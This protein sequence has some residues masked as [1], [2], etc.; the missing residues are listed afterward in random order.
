[1]GV[2][3]SKQK[4]P[5]AVRKNDIA[6][7]GMASRFPGA[8]DYQELWKILEAGKSAIQEVPGS[9]WDWQAFWGNPKTEINKSNSKWGGFLENVESFDADF[10]G[11]AAKEVERMDPQQRMML[12]LTWSCFEDAALPPS[13]LSGK[14]VGVFLGV[15]N[16]DYKELQEKSNDLSIDAH[17]ST[18]TASAI[19]PNRVSYYFN[20]KGP[21]IPID[22]ACSSSLN[23]IH[24]AIQ[25]LNSGE[26]TLAVAGGINLLLTPTRHISFSKT[27]MLSPTGSCKT[28]DDGA[29]GYVRGEGAGL[30]LLK[31][32]DQALRDKNNI[33]GIIKGSA[34]NHGG[35]TYSL[36]YPNSD[37]QSEVIVDAQK[38]A[39][40]TSD[41]ISYMEAHGTGTPKGD[42][43][44]FKGLVD[45][46][47]AN[48]AN[49]R[50]SKNY[51]GLGS[52]KTNLGHLE[53]AAGVAGVIK[54]LL[55]MR[56][57]QLPRL[58]NF[59][60]LN[61]RIEVTDTPFYLVTELKE[62][63]PL[64]DK[65]GKLLPRRA[66]VS[67]F[68]FGGT[69]AHV[70]IQEA[71]ESAVIA[72]VDKK[73]T[74]YYLIC[75]SAKTSEALVRKQRDLATWLTNSK[76]PVHIADV[77]KTL[78]AGRE[79]F[80]ERMAIVAESTGDLAVK[81]A[82]L[83]EHGHA[84]GCIGGT[85]PN[86]KIESIHQLFVET[87]KNV[88][89]A[90]DAKKRIGD[91][92]YFEKLIVLAELYSSGYELDWQK[93]WFGVYGKTVSMPVYPFDK[94]NHWIAQG[95]S[96]VSSLPVK[97]D[98]R[99][100]PLLGRNTSDFRR[101][102]FSTS[103][104]GNEFF[105]RD[106]IIKGKKI[107]PA[108]AYLEMAR[109]AMSESV[110]S[111]V[112]GTLCLRNIVWAEPVVVDDGTTVN[113][114][115]YP[116]GEN[117][118][119]FEIFGEDHLNRSAI[120][121]QGS[122]Q[123]EVAAEYG[124][125]PLSDLEKSCNEDLLEKKTC[126]LFFEGIGFNYG[127]AH[128]ALQTV[129][130]GRN[131]LLAKLKLDELPGSADENYWLHPSMADAALQA[132]LLLNEFSAGEQ[133]KGQSYLPF[134]LDL[135]SIAR[136]C[137]SEMWA[138]VT[139]NDLP[140]KKQGSIRRMDIDLCDKD[141]R[142]CVRM[143]GFSFK[144]IT[145]EKFEE[146]GNDVLLMTQ[147]WLERA[148]MPAISVTPYADHLVMACGFENISELH[149]KRELPGVRLIILQSSE[150][151]FGQQYQNHVAN[152]F[153]EIQSLLK[154]KTNGKILV[155]ILFKTEV[156]VNLLSGLSALL[157]TAS[158]E[159]PNIVGQV[160]EVSSSDN[161]I[162]IIKES[163]ATAP[164]HRIRY[165]NGRRFVLGWKDL[166]NANEKNVP[167][168][169]GGVY[170]ITGGAGGLGLIF[171]KEI[172]GKTKDVSLVLAGR[173]TMNKVIQERV[174]ALQ[175]LGA[176]VTYRQ[177]DV[178]DRPA[179]TE[180]IE[181]IRKDFN[182]LNGIIHSAGIVKDNFMIRKSEDELTS[183]LSPKVLGVTYL[184]EAT[185]DVPLDFFILFSS[186]VGSLGNTG[187][188][189]YAAA[190]GYLDDYARYRNRL[191]AA[192][193]RKGHAI[194]INWPL[195]RE[196]GMRL[197]KEMEKV[198]LERMKMN[199]LDTVSGV[200]ALYR[201]FASGESQVMI[202]SGDL[203]KLRD[204]FLDQRTP[205]VETVLPVFDGV[206]NTEV[207]DVKIPE[208]PISEELAI[209][210][211]KELLS[212][213]IKRPV[214][215]IDADAA[216]DQYGIDSIMVVQM[217]DRMESVF[218]TLPKTLFF[219]FQT[220][221]ELAAYFKENHSQKLRI[222][223][224]SEKAP[225]PIKAGGPRHYPLRELS[226][227]HNPVPVVN[228]THSRFA[229]GNHPGKQ[230]VV[231]NGSVSSPLDVA[232]IGVAGRYPQ[233]DNLQQF[234]YNLKN[235]K[236]CITEIPKD[237]WDYQLYFDADKEKEGKSYSK[238]GGFVNDVDKFDPLFF[239]ITP[240]EAER[241]DPQE[242]LF[243]QC[244]YETIE[245][246]GYT[247]QS[248]SGTSRFGLGN[249]VGVYVG[250]MYEEYQLLGA[251]ETLLGRPVALW[252]L[253][254]SIANRVSYFCDF[255]GPSMAI[256]TMCSS[257]ITAIH[258]AC[259][260]IA[261]GKCELAIAGGVNVSVHP[262]K[263][264][265][266]SQGRFASS[267]GRCESFGKGGDGY[268]PGE[269]VG[270]VLLKPLEKAITDGDHIYG[271]IKSTA[272]NHGG[273]TN[274]Y[275]VPNPKAQAS[276]ISDALAEGG[277]DARAISYLE[278]H[279]TGTSLGDPI[280][281]L[282]LSKSFQE[283]T[284]E[285]QFC[286]IGSAKSNIGHCESA[287]GIAGVTK[288]LLQLKHKQIVPS[289]H[290]EVL[291]ENINFE[292]SPFVVQK[293]LT[294]WKRPLIESN[295][296]RKEYPRCAGISSFGAGGANAHMVIEEYVP[297]NESYRETPA[298]SQ[299]GSDPVVI[300]LSGKDDDRLKEQARQLLSIT[301]PD[302]AGN[303]T[304]SDSHLAD[305]AYTLQIGRE[306]MESRLAVIVTSV[307]EL[308]SKLGDY[309]S[310]RPSAGLFYGHTNAIRPKQ[311]SLEEIDIVQQWIDKNNRGSILEQWVTGLKV[312]WFEINKTTKHRRRI[313]LPTYPFRKDRYWV[314]EAG[315]GTGLLPQ[316]L[317]RSIIH[318][319]V[320]KNISDF[321][322]QR[323]SVML[324]GNE[325]FLKDHVVKG[326]KVLPAAA[327][328]EM[329][330]ESV[331]QFVKSLKYEV[332]DIQL[333][334]V[335][336]L[337][338]CVVDQDGINLTVELSPDEDGIIRVEVRNASIDDLTERS[339]YSHGNA[340]LGSANSLVDL[341]ETGIFTL[342]SQCNS[343]SLTKETI[344]A[345]FR[346]I[347][348][349]YGPTH[350]CL[351]EVHVGLNKI[352]AAISLPEDS[353]EHSDYV[354]YP[355]L[356][357]S[358]LQATLLW[359]W[360]DMDVSMKMFL[361]TSI[362]R[363][364]I[365]RP[366]P[367]TA[368]VVIGDRTDVFASAD[369][370]KGSHRHRILDLDIY[371]TNGEHCLGL[372]GITLTAANSNPAALH[373]KSAKTFLLFPEWKR[374]SINKDGNPK[375]FDRALLIVCGFKRAGSEVL[376]QLPGMEVSFLDINGTMDFVAGSSEIF[377][378]VQSLL[379]ERR[380]GDTFVQIL[381]EDTEEGRMYASV[382]AMLKTA[383]K[384][385]PKFIGQVICVPAE[386]TGELKDIVE[387]NMLSP[388]DKDVRYIKNDR[389]VLG[390][391]EIEGGLKEV[392]DLPWKDEAVYLI[393][394]GGGGLG[395]IMADEIIR[396]TKGV[397][398]VLTGRSAPNRTTLDKIDSWQKS[399]SRIMYKQA[400]VTDQSS[401]EALVASIRNECGSLN[402][403]IHSAGIIRDNFFIN[404]T[405][406]EWTEV[407]APKVNGI[408]YLDQLTKND[409]LDFF[410]FFSSV[411]GALGNVGQADYATANAFMDNYA[412]GRNLLVSAGLRKGH[413]LSVNWPLWKEGGMHVHE[414]AENSLFESMGIRPLPTRSAFEGLYNAMRTGYAQ[415]MI[416]EGDAKRIH[417]KILRREIAFEKSAEVRA[418]LTVPRDNV[419]EMAISYFKKFLSSE[420]KLP[421][422]KIN[423]EVSMEEYGID[424]VMVMKMTS[425][426]EKLFGPLS[427]TL[428]FEY[429]NIKELS[430][431]FVDEHYVKVTSILGVGGEAAYP[432]AGPLTNSGSN[433]VQLNRSN[434][435]ERIKPTGIRRRWLD[436][437]NMLDRPTTRGTNQPVQLDI[438]II[439][440]SG[441]YPQAENLEKFWENL[442]EG[443]DSVTEIPKVRW[444]HSLYFDGDK[445]KAGK[446][447]S[448]WGGFLSGVDEFDPLFF[449]ISPREAE[450]M[451]P[452]ERLFLQCAY[453]TVEDAGY[454]RETI[455]SDVN[456]LSGN[457]GVFA[458]VMYEEYQLFGVAESMKGRNTAL[459][460]NPA[461]IA[462]RVSYF[463][464]F[465]G[466]SMSVDTM[467]SSSLTAIYLACQSIQNGDCKAAI[468]GGVNVSIHPNKYLLLA[469]G[470]FISSKGRCESF[471]VGG[472]GY[473]P[474]E[475][476][477]SVFLKPLSQA[478]ADGDNIY[479]VIKAASVNHGGKTNGYTVPNP[480]AQAKVIKRAYQ[481]SGID[482]RTISYLEAHGT[483]TSLGDPIEITGLKKAFQ[484]YTVDKKFCAIGSV[485]SNI[486]HCESAAGIAGLTK[487]LLQ[488][489]HK[490][491]VPSL[492][493]AE[494]N[495]HID[496]ENSPFVVQ[497][498]FCDW[499]RPA[500][501]NGGQSIEYPR[502]AGISSFGAGGS[503]AHI[504]I[505]EFDDKQ[506]QP[507][508]FGSK[509]ENGVNENVVILLSAKNTNRL[510]E[511]VTKVLHAIRNGSIKD[512]DLYD[513]AFTYQVGRDA[514][515]TRLALITKSVD[516][517]QS[518]L[519]AFL[520]GE[521]QITNLF[522]GKT[523]RNNETIEAF[524]SDAELQEAIEKWIER[525]KYGKLCEFWVKGL[526]INWFKL[527]TQNTE[528]G[529]VPRKISLPTYPFAKERYWVP[530]APAADLSNGINA[531]TYKSEQHTAPDRIEDDLYK[532]LTYE[533][534]WV[535]QPI[536]EVFHGT[537]K[538]DTG[539]KTL[540]CFL[541]DKDQQKRVVE[542]MRQ[543][544]KEIVVIFVS[545]DHSPSEFPH[546]F[547]QSSQPGSYQQVFGSIV[548][549]HGNI[550]AFVYLW[551]AEDIRMAK[552]F[553]P[554]I[555]I[556]QAIGKRK[557]KDN[558]VLLAG[559]WSNSLV[560]ENNINRCYLESWIGFVR[561][562]G[563]VL[564]ATKLTVLFQENQSNHAKDLIN[565]A[566]IWDELRISYSH[567]VLYK[568]GKRFTNQLRRTKVVAG[569][570][571]LKQGGTYL[572]TGGLG[573]LGLLFAKHLVE[574][575]EANL[576]LT[577]R[578]P[579]DAEKQRC[580][581][582]LRTVGNKISY[583]QAD[584]GDMTA[585]S[586]LLRDF[587]S[588]N[589][590]IHAAGTEKEG[591]ILDRSIENFD[592][593]ISSKIQGTIHLDGLLKD[594]PLDFVCYFSSASAI[595]GDFGSCDYAIGNRF[596]MAFARYRSQLENVGS[597][598]GKTIAIN[599]PLWK[600]GGMNLKEESS[601][602]MY[603]KSSGQRSLE[604]SEGIALFEHLLA[605]KESSQLVLVGKERK[606]GEFL[607]LI[608]IK[609]ADN[610]PMSR[611]DGPFTVG[612]F[613]GPADLNVEERIQFDV[614]GHV[615]TLLKISRDNIDSRENFADLGFDSVTLT[616]FASH[617]CNHFGVEIVPALFFSYSTIEKLT[618][619][620][621][622]EHGAIISGKYS[623]KENGSA[624]GSSGP[625]A[626]HIS[627]VT[628]KTEQSPMY[629]PI[630]I[631]GMS[632]RFP[633][634]RNIEEMWNILAEGRN[635]VTEIPLDRFDWH[636]H[637]TDENTEG[638]TNCKWTGLIP[639]IS[640]FDPLFFGISPAE[641]KL[642]DPRQ[643]LLLQEGWKALED[644]GYGQSQLEDSRV[645]LF[646]G[647]EEGTYAE[648]VKQDGG[649][650]SN[651]N[652]ILAARLSY[653]LNL[654]GPNMAIN[655][656]CS[657]G[658][659]AAHQAFQSLQNGE[660]DTAI[661]AGVNLM[662]TPEPYIA[663][664]QAGMLSA[665]GTCHTFDKQANGIVPGEAVAVIVMKRLS[666]AIADGDPIYA[667]ICGSGINYDGRTNGITAPSGLSQ[668]ELFK[669]VYNKYA[670][671]PE[672]V[673]Y[674]VTH[675]TG[676]RLGDP[677]EINAM[678]DAFKGFTD[679]RRYCALS[680]TK[681][682]FGHTFAASGLL[683]LMSLIQAFRYQTI[684]AS[685]HCKNESDYIDWDKTPFFVNKQ[686]K[687]WPAVP[688][689]V[690][691]GAVSAF[692]MSGTNAHMVLQSYD[693]E[694]KIAP[695]DDSHFRLLLLSAKTEEALK[696]KIVD[697]IRAFESPELSVSS[698]DEICY[699]LMAGRHHFNVRLAGI[700]KDHADAIALLKRVL[701]HEND[702][703]FIRG[704]VQRGFKATNETMEYLN[705]L[706]IA[707]PG[708]KND[709]QRLKHNLSVIANYYCQGYDVKGEMFFPGQKPNRV[710]LP[711]YPF[712]REKYWVKAEQR[713]QAR[714][715]HRPAEIENIIRQWEQERRN[716][717]TIGISELE[718]M[719]SVEEMSTLDFALVE[720]IYNLCFENENDSKLQPA[721]TF[722]LDAIRELVIDVFEIT[723][724]DNERSFHEYGLDSIMAMKLATKLEKKLKIEVSP[725]LF[726]EFPNAAEL[727]QHLNS[728]FRPVSH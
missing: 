228:Q 628:N 182:G 16:F 251:Q 443:R 576:I 493:S 281:I 683:S 346:E 394:G 626:R 641:A 122:A 652:A 118:F 152:V 469:Q 671:K 725:K 532:L 377:K 100:H 60:R 589:G 727:A 227:E 716:G 230:P 148:A 210:Y 91:T 559:G 437:K 217:T 713:V 263:Y 316:T 462:N 306:H 119:S 420:V 14:K 498:T 618:G 313:S 506:L 24:C 672:D 487:I 153:R 434:F 101:Q 261:R 35:K 410:I 383:S 245:D 329:M 23:A 287:A 685:L 198:L 175:S 726:M 588:I 252:G 392:R 474:G 422:D 454:N 218:G 222:I 519:Q 583:F 483:G 599:W 476:V 421:V 258:L 294:E 279:G 617:L 419:L 46:F 609:P 193:K 304:L 607:E 508:S 663:M 189:D 171:A 247:K 131:Q 262:N 260:S 541:S 470:K 391:R 168:K 431:Y 110:N 41:S 582:S 380:T 562:V 240:L 341:T 387:S 1:M 659:V 385:N 209:A 522:H 381:V 108:V 656:A 451:D 552:D 299:S 6:V 539:I 115:L 372:T 704:E 473:V 654:S 232:I 566:L 625:L 403:I 154:S 249:Q 211:F 412:A 569:N 379:K 472:D 408:Q 350:Q 138:V 59:T 183:V 399:G 191:A 33:Y 293:G 699:T 649:I 415:V 647:V 517:L 528:N 509:N 638:K 314:G 527:Y 568:E 273:K 158:L 51:C 691:K 111:V 518:S 203:R 645:S 208:A 444:D 201:S 579:L 450:L 492:H 360:V 200:S 19:I 550:D 133:P 221:K 620:F 324:S 352:L 405:T 120:N 195:W 600:D 280:E 674:I 534:D 614:V 664:T 234:W 632:G 42:P 467:C 248:L 105:V 52:I 525:K 427:K 554:I 466:P 529:R 155:Q 667:A 623:V 658:L 606:V 80:R 429:Q 67:S 163:A 139:S 438:A 11:L 711:T 481:R 276:V 70:V 503:N 129:Y 416:V 130:I 36:T 675:G 556:L 407:L 325:V 8:S 402:G 720:R 347:G 677:V 510:K 145:A 123:F 43:I 693:R 619:Y 586:S 57:K 332:T 526:H 673:E 418:P 186:I 584:V 404:K 390:W 592:A 31:P 460:G 546:Y 295:G 424:S 255:H 364:E 657:S 13:L 296:S 229:T 375:H 373:E 728:L 629:E 684:P 303:R 87:S 456:G 53:A 637:Y 38:A 378:H 39:G 275:T 447:Y 166:V 490:K 282:G 348:F 326:R 256:D 445:T 172:A 18:G 124:V 590:V 307:V 426:L 335:A 90:L 167:W 708:Y 220:I 406:S 62:W 206:R 271:I 482:P 205:D 93:P 367:S 533:E 104:S 551:A 215:Q 320:H 65:A 27:G 177:L 103:F 397:T 386:R 436:S 409:P 369:M 411:T 504:V 5:S 463:Y 37:A 49:G 277:I 300:L 344:Y 653:F 707:T 333:R 26:S 187:Q 61:H 213:T 712:A 452:Q 73:T 117:V 190:N 545:R 272:V 371:T 650:T 465:D 681:T 76:S 668:T 604:T 174:D 502:R 477:G 366:V 455:S 719:I 433:P 331:W 646:V 601:T 679:K 442:C 540:V 608:N 640:E 457:V 701:N 702:S 289:L 478:I 327:F 137:T 15:F 585:M 25:S 593:V 414:E 479:G 471:G 267:K 147:D 142:V 393:T 610:D 384:E 595:L 459:F 290:T 536:G 68:G 58:Q 594:E 669:Y 45:A 243:L 489:K 161:V 244:V 615:A 694:K 458:G 723:D 624:K 4:H 580:L 77:A 170:L 388:Y 94:V 339:V 283:H 308:E 233:A 69:N 75:L 717:Q 499:Q 468:A 219:E 28:F 636:R 430:S 432:A 678:F 513:I 548:E 126:Y 121:S 665:D 184:D 328:L 697:M 605:C 507:N 571:L 292:D 368:W 484:D 718:K 690:R 695:A 563:L 514:L 22:T 321:T 505:E 286:A 572:I 611:N 374:S 441:R 453:E 680:S 140:S 241:M 644:A 497:Q 135:V 32:L 196:G 627:T 543:I 558:R 157:K 194:S 134:A 29:D 330:R 724:L 395:L 475:G 268:V 298:E 310:E 102:C 357:D 10:F 337:Q 179:V 214:S 237:R 398:L 428:F 612:H 63:T 48:T 400:D 340:V 85:L 464:N 284:T 128:Q 12:E 700:V 71:P 288:V 635:A 199:L 688:G 494:L 353:K 301:Q 47:R 689:K 706:C 376:R 81:L 544:N 78:S 185:K 710:H 96:S 224:D 722:V 676:T 56:Y 223:L 225:G 207:E 144:L 439:G 30:L 312:N 622:K 351:N 535:E 515:D 616:Q 485:K 648:L 560:E 315:V 501:N 116:K 714:N 449:N 598:N 265:F 318:P 524:A 141:G 322:G 317:S 64:K 705:Q 20:F 83:L 246:A 709:I 642:M 687:P 7:I 242:R 72:A 564:P 363:V 106:H 238:W 531:L 382:A 425:K 359:K 440:I 291:S 257:S 160:I 692:G 343:T 334:D 480:N 565:P 107:L 643:R 661:A 55:S 165:S 389:E 496:F 204:N 278:A 127:P 703:S 461:S 355:G 34:V 488:L 302:Q 178:A 21:S 417:E 66:G 621:V 86:R 3:S 2:K 88:V 549:H 149:L 587:G 17:H 311:P 109:V 495:P 573:G 269:G 259:E 538:Q 581:D 231:Q 574:K 95:E 192:K 356:I 264:L 156:E 285:K 511:L 132:A 274:G 721:S 547:I 521:D 354:L 435:E 686:L 634:A 305:A 597:R 79:H 40:V 666:K 98:H 82:S 50:S 74:P 715:A 345:G 151:N 633:E 500:I 146:N 125:L 92:Q 423:P 413:T 176:R 188:A 266:L 202:A 338:P 682:N 516:G 309:L 159:N 319:L 567:D 97:S 226:H 254:S 169:D 9:R 173:S 561:S 361:P 54:V 662:I 555:Y 591:T 553:T 143:K 670:V 112:E 578:S 530:Q 342:R 596:Q 349:D 336:W 537:G 323:F 358:A 575:Y 197:A 602:K 180:L 660:C 512:S 639:G 84:V 365:Y 99:L 401:V 631:I 491:L 613:G 114:A 370:N 181:S 236:D 696:E 270:A 446:T 520:N 162:D 239:N 651:H 136:P 212:T 698:M 89:K 150:L 250:V 557:L 523:E 630:A 655:T 113:I 448:K 542:T 570:S 253:P 486:G 44:E 396:K 235:G 577:G 603:L 297:S 216:M 164:E 362:E